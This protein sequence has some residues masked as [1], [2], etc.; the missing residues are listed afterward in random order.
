MI[1]ALIVYGSLYPWRF[2]PVHLTANPLRI[3][4]NSGGPAPLRYLLRDTIVN[5]ALYIPLGFAAHA[6]FR[7]S[8]L[9]GFGIYGPLLLALVLSTAME[10]I[11]IFEPARFTSIVDV[12]TDV[13]G[14]GFGVMAGVLFEALASHNNF[15]KPGGMVKNT[16]SDR[17]AIALAF[18]WVAWLFFPLFPVL[19][20]FD[21]SRKLGI[22]EHARL[23]DPLLLASTAASWYAAGLLLTAAGA[24]I[25]RAW[26]AVTL[27]VIPAQFFVIE[28]Q[29]L[30][31]CD[32][33]A[34]WRASFYSWPVTGQPGRR[35]RRRWSFWL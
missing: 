26:F 18:C 1:V 6:A 15:R 5:I 13:I 20:F 22:F 17:G 35:R 7:K 25:P 33:P 11:Q 34:R 10:L 9:P 8:R 19:G 27:L 3:R 29:P 23:I 28:K 21:L 12:I 16:A 30:P 14:S 2:V 32:A 4:L 24:Q 31:S